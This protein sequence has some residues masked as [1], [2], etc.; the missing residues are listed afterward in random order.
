MLYLAGTLAMAILFLIMGVLGCLPDSGNTSVGIGV[1]MI[2]ITLAFG[3]TLA[4]VCKS[5]SIL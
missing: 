2:A 1:I 5:V 3:F 4:P